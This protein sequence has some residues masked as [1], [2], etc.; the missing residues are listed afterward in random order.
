MELEPHTSKIVQ[1]YPT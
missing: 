1:R